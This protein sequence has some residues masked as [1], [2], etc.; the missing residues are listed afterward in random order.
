MVSVAI[1]GNGRAC[2]SAG[3]T[4][5]VALPAARLL[6]AAEPM[7]FESAGEGIAAMAPPELLRDGLYVASEPGHEVDYRLCPM[8]A[9]A[10][11]PGLTK[12]SGPASQLP[13]RLIHRHPHAGGEVKRTQARARVVHLEA[14][15]RVDGL[16]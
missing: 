8:G 1:Q 15:G 7:L 4:T 11:N 12:R 2:A 16:V 5:S 3:A 9:W 10:A 13:Q 6:S 14:H